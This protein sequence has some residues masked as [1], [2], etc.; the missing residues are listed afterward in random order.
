MKR[1]YD[2]VRKWGAADEYNRK[3]TKDCGTWGFD[4]PRLLD[5]RKEGSKKAMADERGP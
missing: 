3:P 4:S 1:Q 5:E 2:K